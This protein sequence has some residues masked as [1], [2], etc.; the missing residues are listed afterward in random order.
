MNTLGI[1]L[2]TT[3]SV[4]YAIRKGELE[5]VKIYGRESTPSVVGWIPESGKMVAG[6]EAKK[7][8]ML[9]PE[10]MIVSNKRNMGKPDYFY[11]VLGNRYSPTDIASLFLGYLAEG[12]EDTLGEK[13]KKVVIT[14]PAYFGDKQREATR[15]AAEMAGL[16]VLLLQPEPTAAAIAYGLNKEKD[17]TILVYD[18]GGGTFD[19]ALMKIKGNSFQTFAV[20]GDLQLGGDD[21]DKAIMDYF[22]KEIMNNYGVDLKNDKSFEARKSKQKLKEIAE[23]TKIELSS[24]RE[25]QYYIPS[26]YKNLNLEGTLT[27]DRYKELIWPYLSKT[28]AILNE[29][30]TAAKL[31]KD[32]INRVICVGGSTK[33]P[34]IW[35]ILEKE[36]K[37]P[38]MAPDVDKIVAQ[39]AAI[40]AENFISPTPLPPPNYVTPNNYG[41]RAEDDQFSVVI[42]KNTTYPVSMHKVYTT[43]QDYAEEIEIEIFQG[44]HNLCNMNEAIDGFVFK[45]FQREKAGI[46]K[47]DVNFEMDKNGILNITVSD[48]FTGSSKSLT[49]ERFSPKP[50]IPGQGKIKILSELT[51]A[52]SEI[53]F[54]DVGA[55]LTNLGLRWQEI[56][57]D[58]FSDY[59]F[60][61]R[62]DVIFINCLAGGDPGSNA[63]AL[64]RFV[65]EGGV[66]YASDCAESHIRHAFPDELTFQ[67]NSYFSSEVSCKISNNEMRSLLNKTNMS[68]TFNSVLYVAN[69]VTNS[70]AEIVLKSDVAGIGEIPITLQFPYDKGFVIYTAFHN[71][72]TASK[73]EQELLKYLILK[74]IATA[75]KTSLKELSDS[76]R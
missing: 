49:I 34:L 13:I 35:E 28:I 26:F 4:V 61:K 25:A 67:G 69:E 31:T 65:K 29:T 57:D 32:D 40:T 51:I 33:S 73:D 2:G 75:L 42:P 15:N 21:F 71:Y 23:E 68:I 27:R 7:R 11:E 70:K 12:A 17:Q 72:G 45:G 36:V 3:N 9:S 47:I 46:P 59:N 66:L 54:D 18:L 62:F 48:Q 63:P 5:L 30:L 76:M 14:V 41:I 37:T 22:F 55:I 44:Q 39:G 56:S 50:F 38:Y 19:V 52:V 64:N 8:I 58:K 60:L 53:G 6:S 43:D 74:P 24:L 20:S 10:T 1:D 16:E